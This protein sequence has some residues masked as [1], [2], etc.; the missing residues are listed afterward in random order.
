MN[1]TL[2][3]LWRW[4]LHS[5]RRLLATVLVAVA[6]LVGVTALTTITSGRPQAAPA[7]AASTPAGGPPAPSPTPSVL[8]SP[9]QTTKDY[10]QAL[11]V[12][13][14]FVTSWASH[15]K[16]WQTWYAHTAVHATDDF[17]RRLGTVLPDNIEATK[18]TGNL[19]LTDTSGIGRTEV[20]VPTDAGLVSVTLVQDRDGS[21]R[22]SDLQPGA[23]AVQ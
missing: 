4:P 7:P 13:K 3:Q 22:V 18:I 1:E 14:A 15:E 17:A 19:R 8:P 6:V 10:G 9:S 2:H 5:P 21:W 16:D 23:Q 12:A 11:N 20:A